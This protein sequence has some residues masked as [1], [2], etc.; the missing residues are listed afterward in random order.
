MPIF[1]ALLVLDDRKATIVYFQPT[2]KDLR[3]IVKDEVRK[4]VGG[5]I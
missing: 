1:L 4:V 3:T 5:V 2:I